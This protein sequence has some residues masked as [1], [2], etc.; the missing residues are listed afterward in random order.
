MRRTIV[1]GFVIALL[2]LSTA[3]V[4]ALQTGTWLCMG[5]TI[6]ITPDD[7]DN[8]NL[9]GTI[10]ITYSDEEAGISVAIDGT[11]VREDGRRP[12]TVVDV[13][14]TITTLDGVESVAR[15]FTFDPGPKKTVW[16]TII[17]WIESEIAS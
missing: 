9:S 2:A 7:P 8:P 6:T 13:A 5:Y 3:Q 1:I 11:Y 10:E 15:Q 17:S 16:K 14:G 4:M 12:A